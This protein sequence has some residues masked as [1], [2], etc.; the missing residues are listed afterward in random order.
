MN[1]RFASSTGC[2]SGTWSTAVPIQCAQGPLGGRHPQRSGRASLQPPDR[3]SE[4]DAIKSDP[5]DQACASH[6]LRNCRC[7]AVLV[8]RASPDQVSYCHEC[9]MSMR[10]AGSCQS[11]L[12]L[13]RRGPRGAGLKILGHRREELGQS[14][15]DLLVRVPM[16]TGWGAR[17]AGAEAPP[18][19]SSGSWGHVVNL[20]GS[21]GP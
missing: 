11:E 4:P 8:E 20:E 15:E 19:A 12:P 10:T 2:R 18:P 3:I 16:G 6:H 9:W 17:G 13:L 21:T 14:L 1:S 7:A 5:L